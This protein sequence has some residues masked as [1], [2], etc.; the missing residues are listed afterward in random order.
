MLPLRNFMYYDEELEEEEEEMIQ[1][2]NIAPLMQHKDIYTQMMLQLKGKDLLSMCL[3]NPYTYT[4]CQN[5]HF[6]K[7]KLEQ[8][9]IL[10]HNY[11][12]TNYKELYIYLYFIKSIVDID[13]TDDQSEY[14][15]FRI[16]HRFKMNYYI[17]LMSFLNIDMIYH[18]EN[19]KRYQ[20]KL[21]ND[22]VYVFDIYYKSRE[23]YYNVAF[24]LDDDSLNN[25]DSKRQIYTGLNHDQAVDLLFNMYVDGALLEIDNEY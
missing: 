24:Y 10:Y 23:K 11:Q 18:D 9:T 14:L 5:Q 1:S 16:D 4:I 8:E 20:S 2:L 21:S 13:I 17:K 3:T 25:S 7:M 19:N 22:K 15:V 6:W 12:Y